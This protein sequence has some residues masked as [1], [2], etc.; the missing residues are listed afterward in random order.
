MKGLSRDVPKRNRARL[1][2]TLLPQRYGIR[3]RLGAMC[4]ILAGLSLLL[5]T[6]SELRCSESEDCLLS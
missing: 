4:D 6:R 1:L 2:V 5:D 3:V